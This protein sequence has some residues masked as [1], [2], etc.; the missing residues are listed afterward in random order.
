MSFVENPFPKDTPHGWIQWKGTDACVDIHCYCGE[1]SHYDGDF[2]YQIKCPHCG[3]LWDTG[4]HFILK[5]SDEPE[6]EY[7]KLPT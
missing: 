1:S 5:E 2:M 3:K 6:D 4:G 7:T